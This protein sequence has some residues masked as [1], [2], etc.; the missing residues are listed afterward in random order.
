[1]SDYIISDS[2]LA[3]IADSIRLKTK[4]E[5]AILVSDFPDMINSITEGGTERL[6]YLECVQN[7]S[8]EIPN[9]LN[10]VQDESFSEY[11]EF[12]SS[13]KKFTVKKSFIGLIVCWVRQY[14]QYSSAGEGE[15]YINNSNVSGRYV[16]GTGLGSLGGRRLC[17]NFQVGDTF[18]VYTPSRA[19]YP[20]Q[21]FKL[22]LA[23]E[24]LE[25]AMD[26]SDEGGELNE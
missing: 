14:R 3:S 24:S 25:S 19:G 20:Q 16:A 13:S 22:Y 21:Y 26:F 2:T 23:N 5:D 18:W 9:V 15:F 12:N 6:L 4:T 10:L 7:D 17:Y 11:I 1:M 8:V